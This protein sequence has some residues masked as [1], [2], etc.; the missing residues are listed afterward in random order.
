ML[1][2]SILALA[3]IPLHAQ[4]DFTA[5]PSNG[6]TPFRVKFRFTSTATADTIT[7]FYWDFGNGQTSSLEDPD[8]VVYN[9][10]GSYTPALVFNNRA[11]LMIVKPDY[12][13]VH[14]TAAA[15][16][17]V[18]D[19][20]DYATFVFNHTAVLDANATYTFGWDFGGT[21]SGSDRR[22]V[23]TFPAQDTF[24]V[25]LTLTDDFGCV[26]TS[27]QEVVVIQEIKVQNVFTP[28]GDGVNDVFLVISNAGFPL[29]LKIFTRAGVLVYQAEGLDLV[30]D[31]IA[32][33]GQKMSP[34][35]YFFTLESAS[36]DPD[37]RYAKSGML[38]MY[39]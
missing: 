2:F 10:E 24:L 19:T 25:T 11:D 14:N 31:G 38:Y 23:Y 22:E 30:W 21:G 13:R 39:K 6:C 17:S 36:T 34:G 1:F 29:R 7:N 8:T 9:T 33:S 27:A 15:T 35:I 26:S 28:N 12:I 3:G 20:L 32:A 16:F 4:Y 18:T 37:A 5:T